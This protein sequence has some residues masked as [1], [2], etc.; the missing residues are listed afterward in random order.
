[1]KQIPW[2]IQSTNAHQ[3]EIG[4]YVKLNL[5]L[6]HLPQKKSPGLGGLT[7]EFYQH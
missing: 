4:A 7:G 5:L 2:K 3:E 6:T 1:M